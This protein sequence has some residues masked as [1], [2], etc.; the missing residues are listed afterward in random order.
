MPLVRIDLREGKGADYI[1]A[2][3]EAVHRALVACL[4]VPPRDHFQPITERRPAHLVYDPAYLDVSRTDD[5]VFVHVT[6]SAG[7]STN[8]KRAFY[9]GATALLGDN[10]G[11][12]PED[13]VI[14]LSENTREDWSFGNGEAR[15]LVRPREQWRKRPAIDPRRRRTGRGTVQE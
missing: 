14:V 10:P 8:Q 4:D 1:R 5:I 6:L 15:Y 3:G 11:L 13:V 12:R 2:V 9:A 7:R